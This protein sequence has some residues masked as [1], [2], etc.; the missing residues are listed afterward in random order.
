MVNNY[1]LSHCAECYFCD[2]YGLYGLMI[3]S[4]VLQMLCTSW[5]GVIQTRKLLNKTASGIWNK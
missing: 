1:P 2:R 5:F 3:V 4:V